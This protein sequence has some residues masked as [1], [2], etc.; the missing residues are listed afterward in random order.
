M[1]RA[2]ILHPPDLFRLNRSVQFG[3]RRSRPRGRRQQVAFAEARPAEW[4]E[5]EAWR[6]ADQ[7]QIAQ[8]VTNH[9][10]MLETV[11]APP[12]VGEESTKLWDCAEHRLPVGV[13]S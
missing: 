5:I 6:A 2:P 10:R 11:P 7:D 13:T 12:E 9:G 4:R 1:F 3:M 8:K